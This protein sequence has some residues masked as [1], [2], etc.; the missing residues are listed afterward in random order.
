[1]AV[2]SSSEEKSTTVIE[3]T[4]QVNLIISTTEKP[5]VSE[6]VASVSISNGKLRENDR[7]DVTTVK[8]ITLEDLS[9]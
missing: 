6:E 1:M 8:A 7:N 4:T 9:K 2:A 5:P 3:E